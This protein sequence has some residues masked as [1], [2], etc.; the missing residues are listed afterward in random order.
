MLMLVVVMIGDDV[1]G[2]IGGDGDGC[3]DGGVDW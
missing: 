2:V 1:D 3:D